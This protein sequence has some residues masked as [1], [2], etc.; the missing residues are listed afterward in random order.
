MCCV[1]T[2]NRSEW[3]NAE[4]RIVSGFLSEVNHTPSLVR[5]VQSLTVT[6]VADAW[7]KPARSVVGFLES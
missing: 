2:V 4:E 5:M 6:L 3:A 7:K 1:V